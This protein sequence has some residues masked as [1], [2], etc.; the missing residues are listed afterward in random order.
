MKILSIGNSFSRNAHTFLNE[1]AASAGCD[2]T[3]LNAYIGGCTFE[4]HMHHADA[5]DK[6]QNDPESTPYPFAKGCN[7]S[8]R[9]CLKLK[10]WDVV[11]IQQASHDSF[12]PE[13]FHPHADRL[14]AT[15]RK[16]AKPAEIVVHQTW[17]YRDDHEFWGLKNF[18]TDSMYRQLRKTYQDFCSDNN[19]RLI[20]SG[21]AF[22]KARLSKKWGKPIPPNL[23]N[24]KPAI[25]SLHKEDKFHANDNGCF[26]IGCVWFETLFCKDVRKIAFKPDSISDE[27]AFV[28]RDIAHRTVA[29]IAK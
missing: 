9:E 1:I 17:A 3:L 20:P 27:D 7:L 11:T 23:K 26:L 12:K 29:R 19:F 4:V 14:I 16:Y 10:N 5:Y 24:D 13:T 18:G 8:L 6:N 28:L 25:H 22:Q 15:I 2:L 21:D